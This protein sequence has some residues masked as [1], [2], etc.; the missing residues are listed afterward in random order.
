[1]ND[2]MEEV[3][4][5]P[6]IGDEIAEQW[7]RA[8][9]PEVCNLLAYRVLVDDDYPW[10]VVVDAMEAVREGPL[11]SEIRE[12]IIVALHQVR[13]VTGAAEEDR[14]VWIVGGSPTGPDLVR[15]VGSAVDSFADRLREYE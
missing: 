13:G 15:S 14:E 12:A 3:V 2:D 5:T 6:P 4:S 7:S 11:E 10:R 9:C 1:M 8:N